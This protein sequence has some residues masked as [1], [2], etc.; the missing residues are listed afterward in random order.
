MYKPR[1]VKCCVFSQTD[2][3]FIIMP[4][5]ISK[6]DISVSITIKFDNGLVNTA[7]HYMR[8]QNQWG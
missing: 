5:R 1:M 4:R 3:R 2:L 7:D 6:P 8:S